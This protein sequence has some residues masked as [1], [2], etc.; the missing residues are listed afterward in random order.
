MSLLNSVQ[1][2][3]I[4]ALR[5]VTPRTFKERPAPPS[6]LVG[7]FKTL[8]PYIELAGTVNAVEFFD[9]VE[10]VSARLL[11]SENDLRFQVR[12]FLEPCADLFCSLFLLCII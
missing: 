3:E 4:R 2:D 8:F 5:R 12:F 9:N 6:T 1:T 7:R 11:H 10:N